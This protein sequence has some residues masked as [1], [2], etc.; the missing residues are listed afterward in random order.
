MRSFLCLTVFVILAVT[1]TQGRGFYHRYRQLSV[2]AAKGCHSR[3]VG[4]SLS[5][6]YK[7]LT[8]G[9]E[10]I[11][12]CPLGKRYNPWSCTCDIAFPNDPRR[13]GRYFCPQG[14]AR[15]TAVAQ[16]FANAVAARRTT[17]NALASGVAQTNAK[18]A[19]RTREDQTLAIARARA[20]AAARSG[21]TP[22]GI[23]N[24]ATSRA[25][26]QAITRSLGVLPTNVSNIRGGRNGN[27]LTPANGNDVSSS[28]PVFQLDDLVEDGF[29][30]VFDDLADDDS[31]TRD[32][33]LND[34]FEDF[35]DDLFDADINDASGKRFRRSQDGDFYDGLLKDIFDN[36]GYDD[37]FDNDKYADLFKTDDT[38][39]DGADRNDD[40]FDQSF[41]L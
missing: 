16:A 5:V 19:A 30:D 33:D 13:P 28:G 8:N 6:C 39:D 2:S 21:L 25:Q 23:V 14:G 7:L 41:S 37:I 3:S 26:A 18:M 27:A 11:L 31:V 32:D 15:A 35:F 36:D 10:A 24:T 12:Q 38:R 34:N 22:P 9:R 17:A 4:D 29:D 1:H 20:Q 40:N